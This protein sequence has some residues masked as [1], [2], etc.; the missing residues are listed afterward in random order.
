[1][2]YPASVF[3]RQAAIWQAPLFVFSPQ[4]PYP[5][6]LVYAETQA[7]VEVKVCGTLLIYRGEFA[8]VVEIVA[9]AGLGKNA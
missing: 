4:G 7:H 1:M 2:A 3:S 8:A 6:L 5:W 9:Y